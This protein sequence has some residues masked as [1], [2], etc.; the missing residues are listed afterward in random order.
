[1]R[2]LRDEA[3]RILD[4]QH[5]IG[6]DPG[7]IDIT[8]WGFR[9]NAYYGRLAKPDEKPERDRRAGWSG[10]S[11]GRH[12]VLFQRTAAPIPGGVLVARNRDSSLPQPDQ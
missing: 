12:E 3:I 9:N 8:L 1:M 5:R 11:I 4:R 2:R 6:V 10:R 7:A